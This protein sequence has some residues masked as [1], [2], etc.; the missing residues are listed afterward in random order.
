MQAL[1]EYA[2]EE[3]PRR[4]EFND[5]SHEGKKSKLLKPVLQQR[6]EEESTRKVRNTGP[7]GAGSR[8]SQRSSSKERNGTMQSALLG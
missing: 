6:R 1:P 5:Y 4:N 8:V 7:G 3:P 2:R